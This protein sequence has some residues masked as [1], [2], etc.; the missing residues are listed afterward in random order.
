MDLQGGQ[1]GGQSLRKRADL[2]LMGLAGV[3]HGVEV[4]QFDLRPALGHQIRR[5]DRVHPAREETQQTPGSAHGQPARA[6]VPLS[7]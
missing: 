4:H 6:G 1:V 7:V 2:G 3:R 5:Q